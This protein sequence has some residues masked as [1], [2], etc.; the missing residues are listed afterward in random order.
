MYGYS[1]NQLV[2]GFNPV[3]P[4]IF[5]GELPVIENRTTS[6]IVTDNLNAMHNARTNFL[7]N[8]SCEKIRRAL[9]YQVRS[10]DVEDLINGDSVY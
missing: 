9:L 10:T 3:L 8:E 5:D 7:K 6:K 1:P 4:S 2:F